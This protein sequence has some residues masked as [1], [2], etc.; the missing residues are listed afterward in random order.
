MFNTSIMATTSVPFH[1]NDIYRH[2]INKCTV[3]AL[4][5]E[6]SEA[7]LYKKDKNYEKAW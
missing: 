3:D 6:S 7:Q 4:G 2:S 1:A 5:F